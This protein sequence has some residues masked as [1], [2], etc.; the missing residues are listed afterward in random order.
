VTPD[1]G[2]ELD[3]ITVTGADFNH[4]PETDEYTLIMPAGDITVGATFTKKS[5]TITWNYK[6]EDGENVTHT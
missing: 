2:Y 3:A 6:D 4:V 5:Y 1:E